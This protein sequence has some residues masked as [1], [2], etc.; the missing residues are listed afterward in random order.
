MT[1]TVEIYTDGAS[2]GNPGPGGLGVILRANGKEKRLS[3]GFKKTTNNR[4]ELRAVIV[5]LEALKKDGLNV[6]VYSDSKYVTESIN[7]GW[8]FN[9]M[10]KENFAN[11]KNPDL[12]RQFLLSYSKHNVR[13]VWVKGH[14]DNYYNN[15]CDELATVAADHGPHHIDIG[16]IDNK[17]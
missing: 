13:F 9:W 6:I 5:G 8:L 11:K 3:M 17:E 1:Q 4:M 10:K 12:W 2:R 7:K 14:A 15:L 16:F